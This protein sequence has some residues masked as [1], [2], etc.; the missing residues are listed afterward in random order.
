M[1]TAG[2]AYAHQV[3]VFYYHQALNAV[4]KSVADM[5]AD[6]LQGQLLEVT[7]ALKQRSLAICISL[8]WTISNL[9]L[10]DANG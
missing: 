10:R 8:F 3:Y 6:P 7:I 4:R 9:E 1:S 5:R 2:Y